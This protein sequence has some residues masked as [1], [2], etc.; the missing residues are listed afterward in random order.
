MELDLSDAATMITSLSSAA[1]VVSTIIKNNRRLYDKLKH[2]ESSVTGTGRDI[3]RLIVHDEKCT[4]EERI[5]AGKEYVEMGG[6]G[7]TEVYVNT[8][9]HK[10]RLSCEEREDVEG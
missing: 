2:L 1:L 3:K 5:N 10:Y 7:S 8:L 9:I 4:I 6:N